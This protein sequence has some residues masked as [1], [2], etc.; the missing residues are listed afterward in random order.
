MYITVHKEAAKP[1]TGA[2]RS[3]LL[4]AD[5]PSGA[6][7]IMAA[8]HHEHISRSDREYASMQRSLWSAK[9]GSQ[10]LE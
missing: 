3:M 5:H 6:V 10:L 8:G 1:H 4:L 7:K 9:T 2:L